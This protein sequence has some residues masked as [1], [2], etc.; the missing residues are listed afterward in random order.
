MYVANVHVCTLYA[1]TR[2]EVFY[3]IH[4]LPS[5]YFGLKNHKTPGL[6]ELPFIKNDIRV[7]INCTMR[8]SPK[9]FYKFHMFFDL[10]K[11]WFMMMSSVT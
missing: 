9:P 6:R 10:T 5:Y 1:V 3:A 4:V 11:K 2:C 8:G 7:L